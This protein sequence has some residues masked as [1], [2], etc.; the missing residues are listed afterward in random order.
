MNLKMTNYKGGDY[1]RVLERAAELRAEMVAAF[2]DGDWA[3]GIVCSREMAALYATDPAAEAAI[4]Y[5]IEVTANDFY[6]AGVRNQIKRTYPEV[7][8]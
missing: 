8:S 6:F 2:N 4:R 1:S 7:S 5:L 3:K